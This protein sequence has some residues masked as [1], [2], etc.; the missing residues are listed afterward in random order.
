V[1]IQSINQHGLPYNEEA[2]DREELDS[3]VDLFTDSLLVIFVVGLIAVFI[4]S[5]LLL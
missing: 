4:T 2:E 5:F 3:G 1:A